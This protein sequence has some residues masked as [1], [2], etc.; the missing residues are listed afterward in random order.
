VH[1]RGG[2]VARLIEVEEQEPIPACSQMFTGVGGN[3]ESSSPEIGV[4]P[5]ADRPLL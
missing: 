3:R 4:Q 1:L 2:T 5:R